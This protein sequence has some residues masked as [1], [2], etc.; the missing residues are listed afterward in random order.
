MTVNSEFQIGKHGIVMFGS[1]HFQDWFSGMFF[2]IPTKF[3][4]YGVTT[5]KSLFVNEIYTTL[6]IVLVTLGQILYGLDHPDVLIDS[7]LANVFY[8]KDKNGIIRA[9]TVLKVETETGFGYILDSFPL[10]HPSPWV[11]GLKAFS[12]P[13]TLTMR[14]E[15]L[16][17]QMAKLLAT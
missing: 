15:I 12:K 3:G 7:P 2:T 9:V 6:G 8:V 11:G 4:A 16:E 1:N 10:D 17:Q 13:K 14:V 5:I